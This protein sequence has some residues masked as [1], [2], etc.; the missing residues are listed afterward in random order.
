SISFHIWLLILNIPHLPSSPVEYSTEI[1]ESASIGSFVGM[2]TAYSLSSVV[3]EIKDGNIGDV[4]AIN[5]NSG[6]IVSQKAL[7]FETLPVYTLT[8]QGTNMAG[9]STNAT[10]LIHLRDENDNIPIF[11][12]SEYTGLISESASVNSVVLT[13]KNVPLVIRATDADKESNAF[14]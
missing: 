4:F 3:Y 10:V 5:P 14:V 11:M 13:D 7:D 6:V 2:V 12:Q 9:L 1:S 8:V